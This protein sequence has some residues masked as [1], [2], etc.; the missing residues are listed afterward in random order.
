MRKWRKDMKGAKENLPFAAFA[1]FPVFRVPDIS[2]GRHSLQNSDA[3]P[4]SLSKLSVFDRC[5]RMRWLTT[6]PRAL[7]AGEDRCDSQ[8]SNPALSRN[9]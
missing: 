1:R 7:R 2:F 6:E 9:C 3:H 4:S 8:E 5:A